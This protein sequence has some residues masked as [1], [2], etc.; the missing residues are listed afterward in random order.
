MTE[1]NRRLTLAAGDVIGSLDLDDLHRRADR[2][3][4]RHRAVRGVGIVAVALVVIA[5]SVFTVSTRDSDTDV[6][7][8]PGTIA[9]FGTPG[10]WVRIADAPIAP[11]RN[12]VSVSTGSVVVV[13]G[14]LASVPG[15]DCYQDTN[16]P[17]CGNGSSSPLDD[18][19]PLHD[20]AA[21]DATTN[22]WRRIAPLPAGI[23]AYQ[24]NLASAS[25]NQDVERTNA[26]AL[27]GHIY[28]VATRVS[29]TQA[30]ASTSDRVLAAYDLTGNRWR[31]VGTLPAVAAQSWVLTSFAHKVVVYPP[32]PDQSGS[33]IRVFDPSEA[34][35]SDLSAPPDGD[36][37]MVGITPSTP[38]QMIGVGDR[39]YVF[40]STAVK[41][42][43]AEGLGMDFSVRVATFVDDHWSQYGFPT[44]GMVQ[45]MWA[46]TGDH[47]TMV[48]PNG[49]AD[50]YRGPA[51]A[52]ALLTFDPTTHEF[53][54]ESDSGPQHDSFA[55]STALAVASN[56]RS[57]AVVSSANSVIGRSSNDVQTD[58]W[59]SI[60]GPTNDTLAD[61]S[62]TWVG[63]QLLVWG[64]TSF[65]NSADAAALSRD[66]W[67]WTPTATTDSGNAATTTT[68]PVGPTAAQLAAGSWRD[69]PAPPVTMGGDSALVWTGTRLFA[70][71][72]TSANTPSGSGTV[73]R[74]A[75]L[76]DPKSRTWTTTPPAPIAPRAKAIAAWTGSEVLIW[77]GHDAQGSI[78]DDGA[79]YN[80][81]T[82]SWRVFPTANAPLSETYAPGARPTQQ[83]AVWNGS[84]LCVFTETDPRSTRGSTIDQAFYD[85]VSNT[86]RERA[87]KHDA[88]G[89]NRLV[90]IDGVALNGRVFVWLSWSAI[91]KRVDATTSTSSG[92]AQELYE[93]DPDADWVGWT[94]I[95][96][97]HSAPVIRDPIVAGDRVAALGD[98][99]R[100]MPESSPP[101]MAKVP[102]WIMSLHQGA[103]GPVARWTAAPQTKA[104]TANE[105]L[106]WT[107][108]L[109]LRMNPTT[110]IGGGEPTQVL[111]PGD[112]R[113]LDVSAG[114]W[115]DLPP[116]PW[117][118][119]GL[120]LRLVWTGDRL[121]V[122]G[123]LRSTC[124]GLSGV[125]DPST[126]PSPG[127]ALV[128]ASG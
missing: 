123:R 45:G 38:R 13:F 121:I 63:D 12:A 4:H 116:S 27:D 124:V 128:P 122:W 117:T 18:A 106:A 19:M 34:T 52:P 113:A 94:R 118:D 71:G 57:L 43:D 70:W 1:L 90:G 8:P 109:V 11:R 40:A 65:T 100:L 119:D 46:T 96:V 120:S 91:M 26:L 10:A 58:S 39:L 60:G 44:Q 31:V 33:P 2:R 112:L 83:V 110:Q 87:P 47:F 37:A 35:W 80:P 76:Y 32:T 81:V 20:G 7:G 74:R 114:T 127:T 104:G 23:V 68:L 49:L 86:W 14:G 95:S 28:V 62:T 66:G 125:C 69:L 36:V 51:R 41:N 108:R 84:R 25:D 55:D 29:P 115:T 92:G 54:D 126:S 88:K 101:F 93:V 102:T 22:T 48:D 99:L 6:A 24:P 5:A 111:N 98:P 103:T 30:R 64:G 79:S 16:W 15:P 72:G 77:G 61:F 17:L 3:R 73:S 50:D 56:G 105:V 42:P 85:P 53:A 97:D 9:G 21:Y 89:G 67:I 82:G 78:V 107:D 75:A 59:T